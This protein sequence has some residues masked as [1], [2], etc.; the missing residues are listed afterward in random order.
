ML[1]VILE[2]IQTDQ[3]SDQVSDQVKRLLEVV[4]NQQV[5]ATGLMELLGLSHRPTFRK[6]YLHPALEVGLIEMTM[7]DS[8]K[9]P[10]Q[11][12]RLTATGRM[13]LESK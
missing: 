10:T 13:F 12:Y 6:N 11:K 8:P 7:P 4:G 9:S 2:S 1:Q 3:V 5:S